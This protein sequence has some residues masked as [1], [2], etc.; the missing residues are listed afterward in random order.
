MFLTAVFTWPL[1]REFAT[2]NAGGSYDDYSFMW[3]LWWIKHSVVVDHGLPLYSDYL[4]YPYESNLSFHT[5]TFL[6]GI[7][8]IPLQAMFSLHVAYNILTYLSF[9]LSGLG[10]YIL[11]NHYV[12][13]RS[14]AFVGGLIF[15]FGP[16]HIHSTGNLGTVQWL[17]LFLYF[18]VRAMED[19]RLK[20]PAV[21]WAGVFLGI[22]LMSAHTYYIYSCLL[23]LLFLAY[24]LVQGQARPSHLILK[25]ALIVCISL[26][27]ALPFVVPLVQALVSGNFS[28]ELRNAGFDTYVLD[29]SRVFSI[30]DNAMG[31]FAL[32]LAALG[33]YSNRQRMV[34][35]FVALAGLFLIFSFGQT[36]HFQGQS[37]GVPLPYVFQWLPV[38]KNLRA[39]DRFL[40]LVMLCLSILASFGVRRLVQ[41]FRYPL[42]VTAIV[43]LAV[44]VEYHDP[45]FPTNE[46]RIPPIY[47]TIAADDSAQAVLDVPFFL[48]DGN[49]YIGVVAMEELLY[50][51]RHGKRIFGGF[52][53][54]A[55]D[56]LHRLRSFMNLPFIRSLL[57]WGNGVPIRVEDQAAEIRQAME[58]IRLFR[59]DYIVFHKK[60]LDTRPL[61]DWLAQS[62]PLSLEYSDDDIT[63]Y[64]TRYEKTPGYS[65]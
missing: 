28:I 15:A 22:T 9:A 27:I 41:R 10:G 6:N 23:I 8:S 32:A 50:Q 33:V 35:W 26:V 25:S 13:D 45:P 34:Y 18:F 48:R 2:H 40:V 19:K 54:R 43:V 31:V 17:P 3:N 63:V 56:S 52:Y 11:V 5:L 30:R 44:S 1:L 47:E 38:L 57:L 58:V 14:A 51:T 29:A 37:T 16:H 4:Y 21:L 62:L 59:I 24:H 20:S 49:A 53:A 46:I 61:H 12:K 7:I 55:E 60:Y 42:L 64:K 36:L 65:V 39:P